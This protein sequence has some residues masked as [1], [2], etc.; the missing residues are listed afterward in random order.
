MR[1]DNDLEAFTEAALAAFDAHA[2]APESRASLARLRELLAT[3]GTRRAGPGARLPVCAHLDTAMG[4]DAPEPKLRALVDAFRAIEPE[5]QWQRRASYDETASAN[6]SEGHANAMIL[7]PGGLEE[8]ADTWFG[9]SLLA[10]GVRYTDHAHAPEE[11]Y[12]VLSEGEFRQGDGDWFSP[13]IGGSFYNRPWI[14][15]AMRSGSTPLFA[16][17]ALR[18]DPET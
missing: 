2:S 18:V 1:R 3:P 16:F 17:W 4:V 15:H 11:T 13:G 9:V 8:R 7:G 10:P 5:L 6:F 14:R 12:L